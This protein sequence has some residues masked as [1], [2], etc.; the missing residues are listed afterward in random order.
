MATR[1]SPATR[2]L[3]RL[4]ILLVLSA[5]FVACDEYA[6][7]ATD[8][9]EGAGDDD[10]SVQDIEPLD[11]EKVVEI[12]GPS[13]FHSGLQYRPNNCGNGVIEGAEQCDDGLGGNGEHAACTPECLD[14]KCGDGYRYKGDDPN[15][16]VEE[17]DNGD[18]NSDDDDSYGSCA[19]DCTINVGCGDS[20]LQ[21]EYELCDM[22][23][24]G[25]GDC[26]DNCIYDG[27][28]VFLTEQFYTSVQLGGLL[29]ADQKCQQAAA[30]AGMPNH[31]LYKA[32]LSVEG[33]GN[34]PDESASDRLQHHD[35]RYFRLDGIP[36]AMEWDDLTDGALLA[37]INI[38][39]TGSTLPNALVWTNTDAQGFVDSM[40]D[41]GDWNAGIGGRVGYADSKQSSWT[42]LGEAP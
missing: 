36:I 34:E 35:K 22:G 30:G 5:Q 4:S 23:P 16:G 20:I 11:A 29:G 13:H 3:L 40:F 19:L 12:V 26:A 15:I 1:N 33:D 8:G 37:P 7:P 10:D 42:A 21:L 17:C 41:C 39:E 2:P 31:L 18:G 38:T 24:M 14:A 28:H 6:P 32:W 9:S 25:G 27:I